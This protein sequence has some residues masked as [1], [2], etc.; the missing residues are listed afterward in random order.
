[1]TTETP[2]L[3]PPLRAL[4]CETAVMPANGVGDDRS[5]FDDGILDSLRLMELVTQIESRF[6]IRV[7]VDDLVP[8]NFD[9]IKRMSHYISGKL[10]HR[11]Q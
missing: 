3:L 7:G 1:M 6:G 5:L 4:L 10:S 9:S 11:P 2:D 8:D